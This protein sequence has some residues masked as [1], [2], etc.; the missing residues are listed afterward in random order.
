MA[1]IKLSGNES[2]WVPLT[3]IA[4]YIWDRSK[5]KGKDPRKIAVV[6]ARRLGLHPIDLETLLAAVGMVRTSEVDESLTK[7]AEEAIEKTE[8]LKKILDELL[9]E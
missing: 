4:I 7:E 8:E 1:L 5:A 2:V 9:E 3:D 6:A